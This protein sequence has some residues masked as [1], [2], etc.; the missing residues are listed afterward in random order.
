M[1]RQLKAKTDSLCFL[2]LFLLCFA[3]SFADKHAS[4][5]CDTRCCIEFGLGMIDVIKVFDEE[6]NEKVQMRVGIH[7]GRVICGILGERRYKVISNNMVP[8]IKT[9]LICDCCELLTN[10]NSVYLA[11][12]WWTVHFSVRHSVNGCVQ[13]QWHGE[14][15][16]AQPG[17]HQ[18]GHLRRP[19]SGGQGRVLLPGE[20][21][22]LHTQQHL[23]F[24]LPV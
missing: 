14:Q 2:T 5:V 19:E 21:R 8:P 12:Y 10:W 7:S 17:P 24:R 13:S 6:R 9:L 11:A 20:L 16:E 15:R 18:R 22:E 3:C 1:E 4:K 23:L